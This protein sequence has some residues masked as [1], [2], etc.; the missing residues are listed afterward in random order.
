MAWATKERVKPNDNL[1]MKHIRIGLNGG[2]G[3]AVA[4]LTLALL[5]LPLVAVAVAVVV[6]VVVGIVGDGV[7]VVVVF[8][9]VVDDLAPI[10]LK[11]SSRSWL[12]ASLPARLPPS[13]LSTFEEEEEEEE[14]LLRTS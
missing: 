4:A 10:L 13:V 6:D 12:A 11:M 2:K 8:D 7:V 14:E 3:A 9:D 5:S 1:Q